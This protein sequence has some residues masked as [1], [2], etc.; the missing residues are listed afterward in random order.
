[1]HLDKVLQDCDLLVVPSTLS[2][3]Q[4]S[5]VESLPIVTY[6]RRISASKL[7]VVPLDKVLG[8]RD[9]QSVLISRRQRSFG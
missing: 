8:D 4:R 7:K 2:R 9:L 1:M 5:L 6:A 3:R